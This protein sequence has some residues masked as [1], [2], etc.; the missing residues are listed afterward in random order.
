[1]KRKE[2]ISLL[3]ELK[4][5]FDSVESTICVLLKNEEMKGFWEL[6][7]EWVPQ[8]EEKMALLDLASKHNV[9]ITFKNGQTIFRRS[10]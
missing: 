9:E 3:R 1:L 4:A 7:I 2:A 6:Q 5:N 8:T 10:K